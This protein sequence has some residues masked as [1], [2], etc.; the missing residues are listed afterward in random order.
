MQDERSYN[1]PDFPNDKEWTECEDC[2]GTG[3]QYECDE[4]GRQVVPIPCSRCQG[5][6]LLEITND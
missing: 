3:T 4:D 5:T 2:D 6:G 1:Q